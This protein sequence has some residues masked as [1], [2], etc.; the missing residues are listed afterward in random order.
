MKVYKIIPHYHNFHVQLGM[1]VR[2]IKKMPEMNSVMITSLLFLLLSVN[3]FS[4]SD[5]GKLVWIAAMLMHLSMYCPRYHPSLAGQPR[6]HPTGKGWEFDLY[7]INSSPPGVNVMIKCPPLRLYI[8][9]LL[10]VN[11]DQIL[12]IGD[13]FVGHMRSNPHPLPV[14]GI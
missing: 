12:L 8:F 14:G 2:W 9:T 3:L 5:S 7:E 10:F 1:A 13:M 6:C 4:T 11:I